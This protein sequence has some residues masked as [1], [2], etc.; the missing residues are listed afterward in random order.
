MIERSSWPSPHCWWHHCRCG[1][2]LHEFENKNLFQWLHSRF[3][4]IRRPS[5]PKS[6][7]FKNLSI[8]TFLGKK[9]LLERNQT[10]LIKARLIGEGGFYLLEQR[11]ES[12]LEGLPEK[13]RLQPWEA[14]RSPG[15][16]FDVPRL[17]QTK[18]C[19]ELMVIP[20]TNIVQWGPAIRTTDTEVDSLIRT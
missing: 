4:K 8:R 12:R 10:S 5:S 11:N 13:I 18:T 19:F 9:V 6:C 14:S 1:R 15:N 3:S 20:D 17:K 2:L 7:Q 16:P